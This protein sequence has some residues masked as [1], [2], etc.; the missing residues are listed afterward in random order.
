MGFWGACLLL[1]TLVACSFDSWLSS[2]IV[3]L[4]SFTFPAPRGAIEPRIILGAFPPSPG[5][6]FGAGWACSW[7]VCPA[8]GRNRAVVPRQA[9]WNA[10]RQV[11]ESEGVRVTPSMLRHRLG[12]PTG[13]V[14]RRNPSEVPCFSSLTPRYP[15]YGLAPELAPPDHVT[16]QLSFETS[17]RSSDA[18]LPMAHGGS[19]K[20]TVDQRSSSAAELETRISSAIL[21]SAIIQFS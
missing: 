14:P 13:G 1:A 17:E 8:M 11:H 9:R 21:F 10:W 4:F 18:Q 20:A 16:L 12:F 6:S 3:V 15:P 2:S 7:S 19:R 5:A